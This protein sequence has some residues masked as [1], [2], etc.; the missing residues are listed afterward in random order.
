MLWQLTHTVPALMRGTN[1]RALHILGTRI[2]HLAN[3][4]SGRRIVNLERL[5]CA[6]VDPFVVDEQP[7]LQ[8]EKLTH[9]RG[10]IRLRRN[11]G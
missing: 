10:R 1:D 8:G 3:L 6:C 9:G 4:A 7:R 2:G 5:S 11:G